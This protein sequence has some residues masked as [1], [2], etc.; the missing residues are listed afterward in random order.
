[1]PFA[2]FVRSSWLSP[3]LNFSS[4]TIS[5][6]ELTIIISAADWRLIAISPLVGFGYN[7]ISEEL[8]VRLLIPV[9]A[10]TLCVTIAVL[11][12]PFA[13]S[14]VTVYVVVTEGL[15]EMLEPVTE[16]FHV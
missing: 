6:I 5:P 15:A 10:L 11:E 2:N 4:V 12:Q 16:V 1:M 3:G 13:P 9:Q 7:L 8:V 14:P